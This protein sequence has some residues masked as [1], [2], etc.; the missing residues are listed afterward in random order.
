MTIIQ[1]KLK[2]PI[3]YADISTDELIDKLKVIIEAAKKTDDL[4]APL[5]ADERFG[6]GNGFCKWCVHKKNCLSI[7]GK[8]KKRLTLIM[9][10]SKEKNLLFEMLDNVFHNIETAKSEDLSSFLDCEA[11]ILNLFQTVKD[12]IEGRLLNGKIVPGFQ[13]LPGKKSQKWSASEVVIANMLRSKNF[14]ENEIFDS[15]LISVS[16]FLENKKMSEE[17][18]KQIRDQF[19]NITYGDLRLCR[20]SKEEQEEQGEQNSVSSLLAEIVTEVEQEKKKKISFI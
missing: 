18:K 15:K 4:N 3:R 10:N 16:K 19:V 1:P 14:Q 8:T 2:K 20:V 12:E 13:R 7:F 6:L 5:I 11:P 17:E 9:K